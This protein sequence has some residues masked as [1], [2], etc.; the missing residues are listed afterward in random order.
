M[1]ADDIIR[2]EFYDPEIGLQSV[3]KLYYKLKS[4]GITKK[5]KLLSFLKNSKFNKC[6]KTLNLY[7]TFSQFMHNI[8]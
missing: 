1:N 3:D 5:N 8:K 7:K 2:E 4:K 6:I